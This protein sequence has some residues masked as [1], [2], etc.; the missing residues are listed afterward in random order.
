MP[1]TMTIEGHISR[2]KD[3]KREKSLWDPHYQMLAEV[4][5]TRKQDFLATITPGEFLHQ[6][7][8]NNAGEYAAFQ[9]ASLFDSVMWPDASRTFQLR[10]HRKLKKV[11]GVEDFLLR[12][13]DEM[14]DIM[15]DTQ[16]GFS[17]SRIEYFA[18]EL[19]FGTAGIAAFEGDEDEPL[20][21]YSAWDVKGMYISENK[22]GFVDTIYFVVAK[23]V[24]QVV[25]EYTKPGDRVHTMHREAYKAGNYE[26]KVEVLHV[27]APKKADPSKKGVAAMAYG[28]YHIDLQNSMLMHEG[29]IAELP[30]FVGRLLK[31]IGETQGR[32]SGMIALPDANSLQ[33]VSEGVLVGTE[34]QLDPPLWMFDDGRL[35][36]AVVDS[37]AGGLSV[38]NSA[39]KGDNRAPIGPLY[40][41]NEIQSSKE[42]KEELKMSVFQAFFLDRLL[43]LN[44]QV[45]MTAYETSVR[46]RMRGE[47]LSAVFGRQKM[48]VF[49][50]LIYRTFNIGWRA[51]RFGYV[52]GGRWAKIQR[53]WA[54]IINKAEEQIPQVII[55]AMD[56]GLPVYEVEYISPAER[57]IRAEKLQG[58]FTALDALVAVQPIMPGIMD[59]IDPDKLRDDVWSLAGAPASSLRTA[60]ALEKLRDTKA[61]EIKA[62]Q[63][64]EAGKAVSEIGRNAAQIRA[65]MGTARPAGGGA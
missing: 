14:Y 1:P 30:V 54:R 21:N 41:I 40:Q 34:K 24:R 37:S 35:G 19:V 42:Y 48:E 4:F 2:Y 57:F 29:G 62:A 9:A 52:K 47:S 16:A 36:G 13:T 58:I 22:R 6:N 5:M 53:A 32:S 11:N 44:N 12:V 38:F 65:T 15:D 8:F 64:L 63:N 17:T 59:G 49:T 27:I 39:G 61:G 7:M 25:E 45:Q 20:V 56:A 50:P 33:V 10:P 31:R 43:D 18:D 51:G 46:N 55:D 23:T 26:E 60:R 28:S 3:L